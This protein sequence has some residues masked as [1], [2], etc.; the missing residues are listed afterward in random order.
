MRN[1]LQYVYM[2]TAC[3]QYGLLLN[4]KYDESDIGTKLHFL[5]DFAILH[6]HVVETL[7]SFKKHVSYVVDED[8][9]DP[10]NM[11]PEGKR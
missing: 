10:N 9:V 7:R 2:Y 4:S 8:E 5:V 11:E 1:Y 6:L 3:K